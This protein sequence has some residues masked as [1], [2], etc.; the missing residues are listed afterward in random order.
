[1]EARRIWRLKN[2][3]RTLFWFLRLVHYA[4][5]SVSSRLSCIWERRSYVEV[6]AYPTGYARSTVLEVFTYGIVCVPS[7]HNVRFTF[8]LYLV[9]V[10]FGSISCVYIHRFRHHLRA[11]SVACYCCRKVYQRASERALPPVSSL[12]SDRHS[13]MCVSFSSEFSAL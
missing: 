5:S 6:F 8:C 3:V 11:L 1:M 10:L 2:Y 7:T 4:F 12:N 9:R 13:F